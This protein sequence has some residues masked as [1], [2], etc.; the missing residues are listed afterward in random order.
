MSD[1]TAIVELPGDGEV[2]VTRLRDTDDEVELC[3]DDG[4]SS[5][6]VQLDRKTL[7]QVRW[8]LARMAPWEVEDE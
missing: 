1:L 4:L 3:V 8:A 7:A 5:A 2:H 6:S